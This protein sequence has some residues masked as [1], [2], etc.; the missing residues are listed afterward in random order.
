[1]RLFIFLFFAFLTGVTNAQTPKHGTEP[2]WS[3]LDSNT[4]VTCRP[5]FFRDTHQAF[6]V[7][8]TMSQDFE[9]LL[10]D[11]WGNLIAQ[12]KDPDF[13]IDDIVKDIKKLKLGTY[14]AK[15]SFTSTKGIKHSFYRHYYYM[16]FDCSG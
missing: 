12:T 9:F 11:R 2:D 15:V 8:D 7:W 5:Y 6:Y 10:F 1:M 14:L 16:G 4:H 3:Q 13:I